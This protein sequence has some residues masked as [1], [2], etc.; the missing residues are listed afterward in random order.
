M[1]QENT[2]RQRR[3]GGRP[4][5]SDPVTECVMVRFSATE[6][7]RFLTL[8]EQSGVKAKAVFIKARVFGQPFRVVKTD[9][10]ALEYAAKLTTF[11]AQFRAVGTNYNQVV[12]ELHSNFS[13]KKALALL[14][15]LE[16]LTTELA[17][18]GQQIIALSKDFEEKYLQK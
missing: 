10:A 5:K 16:K 12:K 9:R 7:A 14:F 1:K 17:V 3:K 6:Y 13:H 8:F 18:T 11:Y 15:K 2:N 4:A